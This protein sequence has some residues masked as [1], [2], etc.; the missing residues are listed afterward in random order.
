MKIIQKTR[1]LPR[2]NEFVG[3]VGIQNGSSTQWIYGF[4]HSKIAFFNLIMKEYANRLNHELL[5]G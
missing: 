2:T 3:L 4:M 5:Q 1:Y